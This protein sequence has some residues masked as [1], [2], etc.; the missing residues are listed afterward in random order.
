VLKINNS[1]VTLEAGDFGNAVDRM[2]DNAIYV[3]KI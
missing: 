1:R 3:F 2:V